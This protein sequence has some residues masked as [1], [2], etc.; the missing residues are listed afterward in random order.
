[1]C[2]FKVLL[3]TVLLVVSVSVLQADVIHVPAEYETIQAGIDAATEGDTVLV[4]DGI[5]TGDG[6]RDLDFGGVNMVV[7][8]E[9]GPENCVIDCEVIARGFYFHSGEASNSVV[10]GFTIRNGYADYGGGV[11][12]SLSSPTITGNTIMENTSSADGGG[13]FCIDNSSPTITGN[14][15]TGNTSLYFGGGIFCGY[16]SS[17]ITDNKIVGNMAS[18][19]G[20]IFCLGNS[21]IITI[22]N[23]TISE[24]TA[25]YGGGIVCH[26]SSPTISGN[27]IT[28]NRSY[29]DGGGIF[30]FVSS[31]TIT[32]CILWGD[33]PDEIYVSSGTPTVTYSDVQGS[34][35]GEGNI[36]EDPMFVQPDAS[37][38]TDYRLLWDSPCIDTGH[39]DS[40]DAD[41]TRS[42]M[43]AHHFNQNDYLTLYVTPDRLRTRAG[44]PL[45][46]TYTAINRWNQPEPFWFLSQVLTPG[47]FAFDVLGPEQFTLQINNTAQVHM[48]HAVPKTTP[49]GVYE[50]RSRIG[51]P[52][53]TLYDEDSFEFI[54]SALQ[55]LVAYWSFDEGE[56]DIAHDYSGHGNDGII[57][58]AS[59][60]QRVSGYALYFDGLD[61][62]VEV[63]AISEMTDVQMNQITLMGWISLDTEDLEIKQFIEGHTRTGEIFLETNSSTT[64]MTFHIASD[65]GRSRDVT[66][67]ALSLYTWHHIAA[68]YNGSVQKVYLDGEPVASKTWKDT[69]TIT[70]GFMLGRDYEG[71]VQYLD[72]KLDEVRIYDIALTD[73]EVREF[74]KEMQPPHHLGPIKW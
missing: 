72:G 19:G 1:M 11:Y 49:A 34:W 18:L 25:D 37:K 59:W 22:T 26:T 46:V 52:P 35:E 30:C 65:K 69:F 16:S 12:C 21:P 33:S 17:T 60:V 70:T 57:Y 27:T 58:G 39:P 44:L 29:T 36:D 68:T 41:G 50:F 7:M 55:G 14:M 48:T 47:G 32:N 74:Y 9:N 66:T 4:A 13:I 2:N 62:R 5:Y 63:P 73:D 71:T 8:S 53:S 51:M 24:N 23:N 67:P 45:D 40:L 31:P 6:N 56:G 10:Q 43:G 3:S 64:T 20:G 54:N 42:D 28:G 38:Y 61:D 15:I